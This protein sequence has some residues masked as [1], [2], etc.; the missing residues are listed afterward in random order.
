M[1]NLR[2]IRFRNYFCVMSNSGTHVA[3][4]VILRANHSLILHFKSSWHVSWHRATL[5]MTRELLYVSRYLG[6]L[7]Y[8]WYLQVRKTVDFSSVWNP[9]HDR[10]STNFWWNKFREV[11]KCTKSVKFVVL[12]R[13]CPIVYICIYCTYRHF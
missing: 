7:M 9:C 3:M 6:T 1:T 8:T 12:A 11:K 10:I 4:Q 5:T 2:K 13:R